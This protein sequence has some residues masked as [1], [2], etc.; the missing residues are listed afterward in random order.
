VHPRDQL[1]GTG[2]LPK[3]SFGQNFLTSDAHLAEI[4]RLV[5]ARAKDPARTVVEMGAGLGALTAFLLQQGGTVHAIER[6]RD[7]VPLLQKRFADA[8]AAGKLVVHEDNVLMHPLG[9]I[10]GVEPTKGGA[11]CGNLPYHHAAELALRALHTWPNLGGACF[12]VQLEVGQRMAARPGSKD[13][14][15]L[16]VV[17]QSRFDVRVARTV[18]R[19]AFWPVPDVDGGVVTLDPLAAPRGAAHTIAQLESVV[20]PAFQQRRKTVRNGLKG[21]LGDAVDA[22]LEAAGIA[23][24]ARAEDVPVDAWGRLAAGTPASG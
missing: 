2:I 5:L 21:V 18:P 23:P 3:R 24:T 22:R 7:L 1:D 4:A 15:S 13:Y 8:L 6:D 14:G 17:L 10:A 16:T 9:V 20:R 11:I 12:L 19:G